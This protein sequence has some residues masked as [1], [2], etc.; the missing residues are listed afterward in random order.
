MKMYTVES[1]LRR[2]RAHRALPHGGLPDGRLHAPPQGH[3]TARDQYLGGTIYIGREDLYW[4][5]R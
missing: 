1:G 3:G 2:C 5:R 4:V